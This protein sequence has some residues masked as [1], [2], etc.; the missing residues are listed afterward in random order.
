L[1]KY[2]FR[3][4]RKEVGTN[5]QVGLI[6]ISNIEKEEEEERDILQQHQEGPSQQI[7]PT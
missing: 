2:S 3:K 1:R 4:F 5:E 6:F 7:E